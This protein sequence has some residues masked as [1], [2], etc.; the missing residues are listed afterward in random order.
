MSLKDE[1]DRLDS[2]TRS[3]LLENPGCLVLP[4]AMSARISKAAHEDIDHDQ[5]GQAVLSRADHDFIR[6]KAEAA[7]TIRV[8]ATDH[9]FFD[10]A[11]VPVIRRWPSG[12]LAGTPPD[13]ARQDQSI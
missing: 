8:P 1:W 2:E 5:H 9:Q 4:H 13:E 6:E 7:G 12:K 10:T 3:W 11:A